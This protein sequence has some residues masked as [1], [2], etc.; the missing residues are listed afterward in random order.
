MLPLV[1]L[2]VSP[3]IAG[4]MMGCASSPEPV[5]GSP[6]T[7]APVKSRADLAAELRQHAQYL[8]EMA[9]RRDAEADEIKRKVG[10]EE[11]GLLAQTRALERQ[12]REQAEDAEQLADSIEGK[13]TV[14][15]GDYARASRLYEQE[16]DRLSAE[17]TQ[18]G[19]EAAAIDPLEDTKGFRRNELLSAAQ[20]ARAQ[21]DELYKR[22]AAYSR[23]GSRRGPST[24][25]E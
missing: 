1:L 23:V 9:A 12:L 10:H 17:A 2:F 6:G 16:A 22:A 7:S 5:V 15:D 3:M 4:P 24:G 13:M 14:H 20:R 21:A 18:F 8:R 25:A 11:Y 19:N